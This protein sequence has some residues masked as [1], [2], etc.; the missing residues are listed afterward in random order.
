MYGAKGKTN[1]VAA[2]KNQ[3]QVK[4]GQQA[5][6]VKREWN[7]QDYVSASVSV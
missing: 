6:P 4:K 1:T 2:N 7:A 5:K 3:A